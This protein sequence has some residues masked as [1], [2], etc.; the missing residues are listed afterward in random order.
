MLK[1]LDCPAT[2]R[3]ACI[4]CMRVLSKPKRTWISRRSFGLA[5]SGEMPRTCST[6]SRNKEIEDSRQHSGC[7]HSRCYGS[8]CRSSTRASVRRT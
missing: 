3:A 8:W 2:A 4:L 1:C 6:C 7:R 5:W